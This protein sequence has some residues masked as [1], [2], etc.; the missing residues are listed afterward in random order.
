M[1]DVGEIPDRKKVELIDKIGETD[2]R[3]TEGANERIQLD[4]LLARFV[5]SGGTYND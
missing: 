4:A 2:F 5:L 3:I 1:F